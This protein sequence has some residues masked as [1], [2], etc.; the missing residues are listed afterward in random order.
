MKKKTENREEK[1]L[2]NNHC[3][4]CNF[5]PNWGNKF[6]FYWRQTQGNVEYTIK[7]SIRIKK[8]T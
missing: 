3:I 6:H 5:V 4:H 7:E 2:K 1:V 8:S